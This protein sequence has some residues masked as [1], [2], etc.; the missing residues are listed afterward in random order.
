LEELMARP[1]E[2]RNRPNKKEATESGACGMRCDK[3]GTRPAVLVVDDE[4]SLRAALLLE[5]RREYNVMSAPRAEEALEILGERSDFFAVVS[6]L[7]MRAPDDG[8]VLLEAVRLLLPRCA[9]VLVSGTTK[10]DWFVKNGTAHRFVG[11]PWEGGAVL[12][13][14]RA[15][16]E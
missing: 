16:L 15:L 2:S 1:K 9:R 10:G 3:R 6:D 7:G 14:V 5:L 13:A 11:K 4:R 8:Y 12:A